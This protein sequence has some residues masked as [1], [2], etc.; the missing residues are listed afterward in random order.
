MDFVQSKVVSYKHHVF[1][2][3]WPNGRLK[4]LRGFR[5]M[6]GTEPRMS[7]NNYELSQEELRTIRLAVH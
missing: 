5:G 3:P 7:Y 4:I 1:D 6:F 2:G